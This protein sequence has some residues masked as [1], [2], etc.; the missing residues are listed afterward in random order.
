M[1]KRVLGHLMTE[2]ENLANAMQIS[3]DQY[4]EALHL[5]DDPGDKND[6]EVISR[7]F[8]AAQS[9]LTYGALVSKM[10]VPPPKR[11]PGC[12]CEL[13]PEQELDYDRV[14]RRC[15]EL[16]KALRVKGEYPAE[17]KSRRVR[18]YFEHFDTRLDAYLAESLDLDYKQRV[19]APADMYPINLAMRHLDY[20]AH[21]VSVFGET[22]SLKAVRDAVF[23]IGGRAQRWIR[24]Y[25]PKDADYRS[26]KNDS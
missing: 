3:T 1:D 9:M 17:I 11:P 7:M 4:H 14:K 2:L 5:M 25:S 18:N 12:K 19:V 21:T 20:R 23:D 8:L 10:L 13:S 6:L 26:L 16:K 24:N 22:V 15:K